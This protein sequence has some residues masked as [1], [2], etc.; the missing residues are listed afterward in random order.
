[1]NFISLSNFVLRN[2]YSKVIN[3]KYIKMLNLLQKIGYTLDIDL[4]IDFFENHSVKEFMKSS[5]NELGPE[6]RF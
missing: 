2:D 1:M 5:S 3:I 4:F 6:S